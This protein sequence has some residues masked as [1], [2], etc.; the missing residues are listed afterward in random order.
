MFKDGGVF[1]ILAT[2]VLFACSSAGA[3]DGAVDQTDS[4]SVGFLAEQLKSFPPLPDPILAVPDENHLAFY[5]DA[6]G[7]QIYTCQATAAGYEWTFQAPEASLFDRRGQ[8]V[9]KHYG[10]P[11]WESVS[12]HS[13]VVA[14]KLAEFSAHADAIPALLLQ[15]TEHDGK[16]LMDDV[17][18]I[19]RLDT[20]GGLA[21][22]AG[23]D[24]RHVGATARVGYTATYFFS[25]PKSRC[26]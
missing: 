3:N 12:D 16:G 26:E 1:S 15:A 21:P 23:C 22:R 24:A 18:Y 8:L 9:V 6:I 13:K 7:V 19:Q 10:G 2:A 20:I 17:S 11:T 14:K 5:Y 4:K 25:R